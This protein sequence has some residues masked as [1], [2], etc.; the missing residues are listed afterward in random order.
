VAEDEQRPWEVTAVLVGCVS[1]KLAVRAPAKEL[2]RS[3]LWRCRRAYAESS[4][5]PWFILS[6]LH[7]LVDPD[8]L[9]DPYD[10][11]LAQLSAP[12]RTAWGERAVEALAKRLGV[13]SDAIFEVHAGRDYRTAIAAPLERRGARIEAPLAHISGVGR[14]HAWYVAR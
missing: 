8:E 2:Y 6:T 13:L 9:L 12:E 7:G 4:G 11:S 10:L 5:R 14:Q 3:P 1:Q